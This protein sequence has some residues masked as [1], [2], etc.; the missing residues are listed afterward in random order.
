MKDGKV[1]S[2]STTPIKTDNIFLANGT[3]TLTAELN[4]ITTELNKKAV[5]TEVT[6]AI[7]TAKDEAIAEA[8]TLASAAQGN[9]EDY[10]DGKISALKNEDAAVTDQFVTAAVQ[11]NGKV[12]VSRAS[13]TSALGIADSYNKST[14]KIATV[15]TVTNAINELDVTDAA[16]TDQFVT[17]V[18]QVDGKITVT[19]DN[20]TNA[21]GIA[22][23]YNKSTN[24]IATVETVN[25]A[26]QSVADEIRGE[27]G[28]MTGAMRF[29]GETT[30]DPTTTTPSISDTL[31]DFRPGDVLVNLQT[32]KEYIYTSDG[33]K[34]LGKEGIYA[35]ASDLSSHIENYNALNTKVTT[36][37][38]GRIN[39]LEETVEGHTT[40]ISNKVEQ[41]AY[42][43]KINE[44]ETDVGNLENNIEEINNATNGIL[45]QAKSHVATE[46][47][48]LD[49]V[50]NGTGDF[51]V[52]LTQT[53]GIVTATKGNVDVTQIKN[54]KVI[55]SNE[56]T[57]S[58]VATSD[59]F[60]LKGYVDTK[61]ASV[62]ANAIDTADIPGQIDAKINA[63]DSSVSAAAEVNNQ[64]SV[65][66]GVTQTDGL[67]ASVSEVKLAAIAKTGNVNDLIQT[68]GDVLIFDCGNASRDA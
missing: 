50:V 1:E 19:R 11:T 25:A 48:K 43:E 52:S 27:L 13:V 46:I 64:V 40:Q 12:E 6:S 36:D 32:T 66:T 17:S 54:L 8:T 57:G 18:S 7:A 59:V 38:E 49:G 68:S 2:Y 21:L 26:K 33:W 45:A 41:S 35:L 4:N 63:L 29:R 15:A 51:I 42:N 56:T 53:D 24:M 58:A 14:N 55:D 16:V 39:T 47:G 10:V 37:H 28:Q 23:G 34:E 30:V 5:A 67:L 22:D 60:A 31:G 3:T 44:I 65:V 62:A 61:A 20:V 9:A